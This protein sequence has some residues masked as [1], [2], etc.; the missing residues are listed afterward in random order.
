MQIPSELQLYIYDCMANGTKD[1]R[2][3]LVH[4]EPA[5]S[6]VIP[7]DLRTPFSAKIYKYTYREVRGTHIPK[8]RNN[9]PSI[10]RFSLISFVRIVGLKCLSSLAF[11][12][13]FVAQLLSPMCSQYVSAV[14][15][16]SPVV[17]TGQK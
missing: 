6:I 12:L 5:I 8:E 11:Q 14:R 1:T 4:K 3:I 13:L 16:S 7:L 2:G 9:Y 15:T 17:S 10:R